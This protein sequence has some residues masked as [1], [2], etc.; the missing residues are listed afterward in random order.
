MILL[1]GIGCLAEDAR[2][3]T[4]LDWMQFCACMISMDCC[5]C[6]GQRNCIIDGVWF[7]GLPL[8][9]STGPSWVVIGGLSFT[10]TRHVE[11][12][13]IFMILVHIDSYSCA[14]SRVLSFYRSGGV[15]RHLNVFRHLLVVR[16]TSRLGE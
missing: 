13:F 15:A 2:R 5:L 4:T 11:R 10:V 14:L 1:C 7:F 6:L 3:Q 12:V 8:V 9:D 16:L